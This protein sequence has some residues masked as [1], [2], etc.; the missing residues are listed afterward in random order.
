MYGKILFSA[1]LNFFQKHIQLFLKLL[2]QDSSEVIWFE[3]KLW[4]WCLMP[5]L[6]DKKIGLSSFEVL[7]KGAS[8]EFSKNIEI[9]EPNIR[10][11][12]QEILKV[13]FIL[14]ICLNIH[15]FYFFFSIIS[16]PIFNF[17]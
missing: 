7:Y 11:T 5:N 8:I 14:L 3:K 9:I 16:Y 6:E 2:F 10:N 13:Y 4:D 1:G 15:F 17:N 12:Q